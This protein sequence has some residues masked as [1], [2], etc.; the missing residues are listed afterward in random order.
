MDKRKKIIVTIVIAVVLM[1]AVT[2]AGVAVSNTI[3]N[4]VK[5]GT[6]KINDINLQVIHENGVSD[7]KIVGWQPSDIDEITWNVKNVGTSAIY[8]RNKIQV[9]FNDEIP[10][11]SQIIYLYPANMT[12][13]QIIEDFEKGENS[14]YAIKKQIE[15][16]KIDKNTTKKGF[17]YEILGDVLDGTKMTGKS[18]EV[19]Y[20]S[21]DFSATSDDSSK[22]EDV[23][24]FKLLFSPKASYLFQGKELSIKVVTEAM[25]C[26][27]KGKAEWKIVGSQ[28]I[29]G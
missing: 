20:N 22:T 5:S 10:E 7:N 8:T 29:G 17:E 13:A 18:S 6:V 28:T 27:D 11:N 4:T 21:K 1:L 15:D 16:I 14:K 2:I 12:R 23:V 25:Q 3:E 19:D 9:Y 26:T 24:A